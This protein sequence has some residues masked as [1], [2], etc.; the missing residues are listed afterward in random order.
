VVDAEDIL[1]D[2]RGVLTKLC[3]ACGIDFDESMLSWRPGPKPFDGIWARHWYNAVWASSGLTQPEPR[4]VTLP[5]ELQR[6]AD[7]AMPYYEKMRPYRLI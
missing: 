6:I 7:A 5:A 1:A 3:S 4:P 2:P